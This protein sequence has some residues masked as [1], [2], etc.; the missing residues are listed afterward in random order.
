M[1]TTSGTMK[2]YKVTDPSGNVYVMTPVDT[3]ARQAIDEAKTL[4]FDSDYFTADVSQDQ[5]TVNVGL[6]GVPIGVET[7]LQF[8]Q[9]DEHGIVLGL[10]TSALDIPTM[11][12][13][14]EQ[15]AG[16]AGLVPAPGIADRAKFLKGDGTWT[17]VS[18]QGTVNDAKLKLKLGSAEAVETGFTANA[19]TDA[20]IDIPVMSGATSLEAGGE[21]LVP[22]PT[23]S[24]TDKFLKGDG[25]WTEL[26]VAT[27]SSDGLMSATDKTNLDAAVLAEHTHANKAVLDS[28][29]ARSG[30]DNAVILSESDS[31]SPR[32]ANW[33]LVTVSKPVQN[34]VLIGKTWYPYVQIGN[35]YWTTENLREPIGTK[36]TDY[37][38]YDD[39][40]VVERGYIYKHDAVIKGVAGV[41]SDALLALLH[42]GWHIPTLEEG[43]ALVQ[44]KANWDD[45]GWEF[46]ATDADRVTGTSSG[47]TF[48]DA[49][50]FKAY[51]SGWYREYGHPSPYYED[52]FT[53][54]TTTECIYTKTPY[55]STRVYA[56][57]VWYPN[58]TGRTAG[59]S[60][61]AGGDTYRYCS[62]RLCKSAT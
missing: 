15:A 19:D 35:M 12:G 22:A 18:Q 33:T 59:V 27:T 25:T 60:L 6:N 53:E 9:D 4:Q 31:T 50:G 21:G 11:T 51:P 42:D 8:S 23:T 5:S 1:S 56:V 29:P 16:T 41:E 34:S 36:N 62:V 7:P 28:I 38:V 39:N 3:E 43:S 14:T 55:D 47:L 10:D 54:N 46:F 24:D 37:W 13:A 20:T 30:T 49:Y 44:R 40:T 26:P 61:M 48:N 45:Y 17:E 2:S 58:G 57:G 52:G 32:W